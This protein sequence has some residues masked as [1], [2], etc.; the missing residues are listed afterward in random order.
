MEIGS[1]FKCVLNI[2]ALGCTL[3]TTLYVKK[4]TITLKVL[5][6]LLPENQTY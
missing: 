6:G 5:C 1:K 3:D 2:Y 4:G